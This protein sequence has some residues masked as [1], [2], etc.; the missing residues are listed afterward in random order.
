MGPLTI[1]PIAV[2]LGSVLIPVCS[3]GPA[4]P[5]G[6]GS[7]PAEPLQLMEMAPNLSG[8]A[9]FVTELFTVDAPVEFV[10]AAD[11]HQLGKDRSQESEDRPAQILIRDLGGEPVEIPIQVKTRGR[12]RL[13]RSVCPEPPLRLNLPETRPQGTVLDG[14]DKLKLVT[15]CRDSDRYEQNVLEEYLTYR[16][17]NQLTDFSFRV[18]LAEITYLDTSGKNDTVQ[19]MGFLIESEDALAAR[20]AGEM[21]EIPAA[22]PNDFILDQLSLMYLFQ[23][24][25]GNID[26]GTGHS[27]NLK[28]LRVERSHYPIP[29][30]FDWTGLVDAPYVGPNPMTE[31]FHDSVRERVYWGACVPGIDY[32]GLFTRFN[33]QREAIMALVKDQVRLSE[34]NVES[35]VSYLEEFYSIINSPGRA[36]WAIINA[37]RKW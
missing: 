5:S 4:V 18:Q 16:I 20:L 28:I 25:V 27:H 26:W 8:T 9:P 17:Y 19:R 34:R 24:M 10:L 33:E 29:Y 37:C 23:F 12:F 31:A 22:T 30:D 6:A 32:Q 14:Q 15:H 2:I 21:V 36:R 1:D 13:K 3:C 35:A 7:R 11:F